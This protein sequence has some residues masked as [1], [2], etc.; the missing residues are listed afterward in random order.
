MEQKELGT[1]RTTLELEPLHVEELHS[2]EL[3]FNI[4]NKANVEISMWWSI[5]GQLIVD[6]SR[7]GSSCRGLPRRNT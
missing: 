1:E 5:E 2:L 4:K 6:Q 7:T 3:K